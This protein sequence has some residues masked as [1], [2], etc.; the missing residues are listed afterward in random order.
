MNH[1]LK[2]QI[3]HVKIIPHYIR[4][5]HA[6]FQIDS[7]ILFY[8]WKKTYNWKSFAFIK[9]YNIEFNYKVYCMDM[10]NPVDLM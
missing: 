8:L 4:N 3:D 10:Y 6:M 9:M 7:K 1:T 2:D 5:R